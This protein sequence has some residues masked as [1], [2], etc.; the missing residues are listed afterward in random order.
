MGK[1]SKD[2]WSLKEFQPKNSPERHI[3]RKNLFPVITP[4]D[5]RYPFIAYLTF[6]YS[7]RDESGLP[8]SRDEEILVRVEEK[9]IL[10][11]EANGLSVQVGAVLKSGIKDMLFYTRNPDEF[12][13]MAEKFRD[14]YPQFK[15]S[16]E[17]G[18]DA[19]WACYRDF[20]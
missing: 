4:A 17:I 12:L 2:E 10:C 18:N 15:V 1:K 16:C 13:S 5:P 20:P 14:E 7:P 6:A 11:L 9:E 8:S 19:E 3:F